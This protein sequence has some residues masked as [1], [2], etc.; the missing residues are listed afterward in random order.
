MLTEAGEKWASQ[1]VEIHA[2]DVERVLRAFCDEVE[3]RAKRL[4]GSLS[5]FSSDHEQAIGEVFDEIKRELLGDEPTDNEPSQG[6]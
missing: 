5:P 3:R 4:G 2:Y 1:V 6:D